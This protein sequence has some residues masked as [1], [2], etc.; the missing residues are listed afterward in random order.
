MVGVL[1]SSLGHLSFHFCSGMCVELLHI[2]PGPVLGSGDT[3][4]TKTKAHGADT[5]GREAGTRQAH[6]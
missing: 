5:P 4:V 2:V 1:L 3:T 6:D